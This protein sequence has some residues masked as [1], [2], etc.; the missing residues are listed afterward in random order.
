MKIAIEGH[1]YVGKTVVANRLAEMGYEKLIQP[2]NKHIR[3]FIK[4]ELQKD[5]VD[6]TM[7]TLAYALD[8]HHMQSQ[9]KDKDYI[10]DRSIYSSLI[11]QTDEVPV[12]IVAAANDNLPMPD[13]VFWLRISEKERKRRIRNRGE[14]DLYDTRA[15]Q[16]KE[17]YDTLMPEFRRK[18][19]ANFHEIFCDKKSVDE[20]ANEIHEIL[21]SR[22]KVND[23]YF[24]P[25]WNETIRD[26]FGE[27]IKH[28]SEKFIKELLK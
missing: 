4:E 14:G 10:M 6:E 19:N 22:V 2:G 15:F 21:N 3:A 26:V 23:K 12:S 16:I 27:D 28:Y 25:N 8:R 7:M 20:I 11:I 9:L 1:D 17:R 13:V 24:N 18:S 5:E